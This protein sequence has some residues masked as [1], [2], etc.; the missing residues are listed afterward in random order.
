MRFC[1]SVVQIQ[2]EGSSP[3]RT[4]AVVGGC[5][6]PFGYSYIPRKVKIY[7]QHTLEKD[8]WVNYRQ[9]NLIR[10][11]NHEA[12]LPKR[13]VA[14]RNGQ[15][16]GQSRVFVWLAWQFRVSGYCPAVKPKSAARSMLE[17]WASR[18]TS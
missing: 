12:R 3:H 14:D 15:A 8:R 10:Y 9:I 17:H 11:N 5:G 13:L 4:A 16:I 2:Y 6:L 1:I 18:I 7:H